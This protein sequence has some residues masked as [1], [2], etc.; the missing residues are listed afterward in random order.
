VC[1][2]G[3][4]AA[5]QLVAAINAAGVIVNEILIEIFEVVVLRWCVHGWVK[6]SRRWSLVHTFYRSGVCCLQSVYLCCVSV[7]FGLL[8][9]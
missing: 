2:Q 6:F 9:P 5:E 4:S 7:I 1:V 3:A 8:L